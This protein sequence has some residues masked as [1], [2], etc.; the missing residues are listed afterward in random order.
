M[1]EMTSAMLQTPRKPITEAARLTASSS[2]WICAMRRASGRKLA[3]ESFA[4]PD[5]HQ[6]S[7]AKFNRLLDTVNDET[8]RAIERQRPGIILQYPQSDI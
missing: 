3:A 7:S 2:A 6:F 5:F 4:E 8:I 1:R